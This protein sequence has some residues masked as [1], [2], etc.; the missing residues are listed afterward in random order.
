MAAGYYRFPTIFEDTVAFACEDDLWAVEAAGSIAR[1]LTNSL[2]QATRPW[3]SPDGTQLAYVGR[4][5]GQWEIYLMPAE[6]GPG[7]RM[8]FLGGSLCQ[9]AGWTRDGKILFASN[10]AHWYLRFTHLY[11]LDPERD[12][13]GNPPVRLD[14]GLAR[15]ISYGP[16]GGIVIGRNTDEPARWK[17]YR[18]GTVGQLW[19][20]ES[21]DG[22]F[23][24]LIR[25]DG[26]MT[27]PMWITPRDEPVGRIFFISDHEGIGNLYSCLPN[28]EDL[29]RHSD[30]ED[31]YVRNASTDG[32]RIVYHAGADLYIYD[33]REDSQNRIQ[34]EFRSPQVQRMRKFVE[35]KNYLESWR[36][37][38][39][40][41]SLAITARG[42]VYSFANW[43]GAVK[44]HA[45]GREMEQ[46]SKTKGEGDAH[47]TV[48]YRLPEW[49]KDGKRIIAVSDEGG[50]ESF[51]ILAA[52]ENLPEQ[53]LP[54]MDIGRP[55]EIVVNPKK[56][57]IVFSNHRYE[58]IFLDLVSNEL[59]L[60]ERGKA[61]PISGFCWSPDGEWVAYSVSESL[62]R[63]RIK[64]WNAANGEITALTDPV[65]HDVAPAF[66]PAGKYLYFLSYRNF[67][68]VY[69]NLHFDINFPRGMKPYLA[70]L[71]KDTPSP[72]IPQPKPLDAKNQKNNDNEP[73]ETDA[74]DK[75]SDEL[76]PLQIHLEGIQQRVVA[77]PV[78]EGRYRRI[79]GVR[80]GKVLY[81]HYP[82]EAAHVHENE[83]ESAPKGNLC[84]YNFEELNEETLVYNLSDFHVTPDG[85]G[86]I[87]RSGNNLRVL[88]AGE[89]TDEDAHGHNRKSGWIDLSRV[90]VSVNPGA[91]WRQMFREAWRLQ[92]DQFWTPDMS[93]VDWLA[94][95]DR[96]LP[97]V[98]R[99]STRSEFSDLM[100]EMQGELGT[101]HAYE[102]GGDYRPEPRYLQGYLGADFE[103]DEKSESWVISNILHGDPWDEGVDSPLNGLGINLVP[104]DRLI[105]I[106]GISLGRR[107]SPAASLVNLAG[108][109]VSLVIAREGVDNLRTVNVKTLTSEA[110]TRYRAWVNENRRQVHQATGGRI[111][112]IHIPDMGAG[113]Y[114][115][116]HRG[117]LAEVDREGLIVD[118]RYNRG[119][120]VSSLLLEK[121]ARRRLGYDITRWSQIPHPY[122]IESVAGPM[123]ALTNEEAG[124]DGDIFCHGF[125]MLKLG[126]LIGKR[127]WGGVI[128][129]SPRHTLVDGTVTTQPEYSFW[130]SDVGWGIENYGTDPDIEVEVT[131]QDYKRQVDPQLERGIQEVLKLLEANPVMLPEFSE[132]P[133]RALPKLPKR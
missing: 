133:S 50:E 97:L 86:L 65:L 7:R 87:Y 33:P 118:V 78:P 45:A 30:H 49:L 42:K 54:G 75:K 89:K 62:H 59:K 100:W 52:D 93:Q 18:G 26:N 9:T 35:C 114:A 115:E 101:S 102:F 69:D 5:E 66:D 71:Q 113:G 32:K 125:K 98:D 61:H 3:I 13:P 55:E 112:Y 19:I 29:L 22:N 72:F 70:T 14:H 74:E 92:R 123:V 129:I 105:A 90:K 110:K 6:G 106:N 41:K 31:F 58:L 43:E 109:E 40:G 38:P 27:C 77:F 16:S 99:V 4:E 120:H 82:I 104:G 12:I 17:R 1:R 56:D 121:L 28:G 130:F 107:I 20:D 63:T 51:V 80:D 124:S 88:K 44:I 47:A 111:G 48:R 23:R 21:G 60:I 81:S 127:T 53:R 108:E 94:V 24:P 10:A 126:P 119:G 73:K 122:P 39:D 76:K 15:S 131:P 132:R 57:Q 96:Y 116:F 68:P 84:L 91:E 25:L 83:E 36:L 79:L 37:S 103:F 117:F 95:H 2:G 128:G 85:V 46:L 8:T 67:D 11:W 64:L 34:V